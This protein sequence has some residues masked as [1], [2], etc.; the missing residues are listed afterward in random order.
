MML[1]YDM[2]SAHLQWHSG[3][4]GKNNLCIIL[5]KKSQDYFEKSDMHMSVNIYQKRDETLPLYPDICSYR[6]NKGD[7]D[8]YI[9]VNKWTQCEMQ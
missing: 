2:G 5:Y 3:E 4:K 1:V 6:S 8:T 7:H 9:P